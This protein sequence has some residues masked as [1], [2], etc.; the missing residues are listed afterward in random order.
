LIL[1]GG[2][3]DGVESSSGVSLACATSA[4]CIQ[5]FEYTNTVFM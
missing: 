4:F 3:G 1:I 2:D 5:M